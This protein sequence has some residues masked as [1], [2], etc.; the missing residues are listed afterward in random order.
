MFCN[1]SDANKTL[2][3]QYFKVEA[4]YQSTIAKLEGEKMA[5]KG[6][7]LELECRLT[8]FGKHD[9]SDCLNEA[10]TDMSRRLM[11]NEQTE[12]EL[13]SKIC[14]LEEREKEVNKRLTDQRSCYNDLV[15]QLQDHDNVIK[16]MGLLEQENSDLLDQIEHLREVERRFKDVHQSEE[17]LQGRVEELEQTESVSSVIY[18]TRI[19]CF[20]KWNIL[21]ITFLNYLILK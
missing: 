6:Q 12:L 19:F 20:F 1:F 18:L 13:N 8:A 4:E 11:V 16:K 10:Y 2:Y 15:N 7:L 14:V 5:L 3:M 17:F 9:G 21:L